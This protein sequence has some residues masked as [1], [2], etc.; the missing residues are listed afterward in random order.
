MYFN[1]V[2]R[3]TYQCP[4]CGEVRYDIRAGGWSKNPEV[5]NRPYVKFERYQPEYS[6]I[7]F[8]K[9][10]GISIDNTIGLIHLTFRDQVGE[11]GSV[12]LRDTESQTLSDFLNKHLKL[13]DWMLK[14]R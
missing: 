4:N 7:E 13:E 12:T 11:E 1:R 10:C 14:F 8:I 6:Q 3:R 9:I 2:T 5:D